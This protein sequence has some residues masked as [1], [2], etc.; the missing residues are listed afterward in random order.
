MDPC[1][2]LMEAFDAAVAAAQPAAFLPESGLAQALSGVSARRVKVL[3]VGKAGASTAA[4]LEALW[5]DMRHA[6]LPQRFEGYALTR[7]GYERACAWSQ[8]AVAGHPVPSRAGIAAAQAGLRFTDDLGA[9]DLLILAI[10]GGASSLFSIPMPGLTGEDLADLSGALLGAGASIGE[11]NTLR[12]HLGRTGGGR[13]AQDLSRTRIITL[14]LSDVAGDDPCVIGSGPSVGDPTTCADALAVCARYGVT[15]PAAAREGLES[16]AFET[17]KPEDPCFR[18]NSPP[19]IV[20]PR[21]ALD[22]AQAVLERRGVPVVRLGDHLEGP[23]E[24]LAQHHAAA[25]SKEHGPAALVSGGEAGV[26][27]PK[28]IAWRAPGGPNRHFALA[29]ALA[30]EHQGLVGV[31]ALAADTDGVDGHT[32]DGPET[33]GALVLPDSLSRARALGLDPRHA[34]ERCEAGAIFAALGDALTP[35]PTGTN[36][37]DLRI[38]LRMPQ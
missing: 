33:A 38:V 15:L 13:L 11:I 34:L 35:G 26:A 7:A 25:L 22:A 23:A 16:G 21:I 37:N 3:S 9:E 27:V 19:I 36:V 28:D 20:R 10:S 12:K 31:Y 14:C 1:T 8:V 4:A 6:G 17:P 2:L 30:L 24:D 18:G 5:P 32:G 29:L